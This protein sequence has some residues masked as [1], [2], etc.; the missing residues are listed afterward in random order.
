MGSSLEDSDK[1]RLVR[2][3]RFSVETTRWLGRRVGDLSK[4]VVRWSSLGG[5]L[6]LM[7]LL[8]IERAYCEIAGCVYEGIWM[9]DIV[10]ET[11][12]HIQ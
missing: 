4:L 5:C 9:H 12:E 7:V 1:G 8:H 11:N 3:R 2:V 6:E 10:C